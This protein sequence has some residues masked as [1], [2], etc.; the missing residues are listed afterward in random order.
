[1][2]TELEGYRKRGLQTAGK[3]QRKALCVSK[4]RLGQ[5]KKKVYSDHLA[6][7]QQ[8]PKESPTSTFQI[9]YAKLVA[10]P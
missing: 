7:V 3:K 1:M 2:I 8:H 10:I 9:K 5:A 4:A 6:L